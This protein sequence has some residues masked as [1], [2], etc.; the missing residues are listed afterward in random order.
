MTAEAPDS[1][2]DM[3]AAQLRE[4]AASLMH[5]LGRTQQ[6]LTATKTL[7]EKLTFEI[8]ALWRFRFGKRG[9]QLPPGVQGRLLEEAVDEDLIEIAAQLAALGFK[10]ASCLI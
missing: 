5:T 3:D 9:E 7:N 6:E 1:L 10:A 2:Q 8:A 4:L